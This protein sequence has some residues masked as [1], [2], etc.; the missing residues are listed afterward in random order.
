[1]VWKRLYFKPLARDVRRSACCTARRTRSTS[2][3]RHRRAARSAH[4]ARPSAVAA[5]RSAGTPSPDPWRHRWSG[6][7]AGVSRDRQIDPGNVRHGA[8]FGLTGLA[9]RRSS[10]G[11]YGGRPGRPPALLRWRATSTQSVYADLQYHD[12]STMTAEPWPLVTDAGYGLERQ[13][14][15]TIIS[16]LQ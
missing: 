13:M 7:R 10:A 4:W 1:M 16:C 12:A 9:R 5:A 14:D 3:S 8:S 2:R 6:R 15:Y 11:V